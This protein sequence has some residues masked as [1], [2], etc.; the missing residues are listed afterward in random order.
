[1]L[2]FHGFHFRLFYL[3]SKMEGRQFERENA[4]LL[5]DK[6]EVKRMKRQFLKNAMRTVFGMIFV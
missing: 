2:I 3:E 6:T 5:D 4:E 1:M